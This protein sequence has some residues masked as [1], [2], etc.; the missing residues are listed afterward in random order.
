MYICRH[1]LDHLLPPS[2]RRVDLLLIRRVFWRI[3]KSKW[4]QAFKEQESCCPRQSSQ[5]REVLCCNKEVGTSG[6]KHIPTPRGDLPHS[7]SEGAISQG[8][9]L[10]RSWTEGW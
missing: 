5:T 8:F 7:V 6:R 9:L 1:C 10:V 2:A 3:E 4:G